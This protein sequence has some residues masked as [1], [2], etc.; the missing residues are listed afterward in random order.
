MDMHIHINKCISVYL[1]DI[2]TFI[3]LIICSVD[4]YVYTDSCAF[5]SVYMNVHWVRPRIILINQ[6]IVVVIVIMII[7]IILIIIIIAIITNITINITTVLFFS[8]LLSF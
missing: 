1:L 4:M 2:Y 7:I 8:V 6:P 3:Y 5:I